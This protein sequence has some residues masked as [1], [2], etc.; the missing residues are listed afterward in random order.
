MPLLIGLENTSR[1]DPRIRIIRS[2]RLYFQGHTKR[3]LACL[4]SLQISERSV[5]SETLRK[6]IASAYAGSIQTAGRYQTDDQPLRMYQQSFSYRSVRSAW[7]RPSVDYTLRSINA[8]TISSVLNE[9]SVGNAVFVSALRSDIQ[10]GIGAAQTTQSKTEAIGSLAISSRW[11]NYFRSQ[12][13][14]SRQLYLNSISS[15]QQTVLRNSLQ[16]S[17]GYGKNESWLAEASGSI[18]NFVNGNLFSFHAWAMS[19]SLSIGRFSTRLGYSYSFSDASQST[20]VPSMSI[21]DFI[22]QA[23]N[24]FG[25]VP[26]FYNA[27]FSPLQQNIHQAIAKCSFRINS[28]WNII[29]QG[30]YGIDAYAQV[31]YFYLDQVN[32]QTAYVQSRYFRSFTPSEVSLSIRGFLGSGYYLTAGL[33]HLENNF[34]SRN[35]FGF[36]LSKM[37]SHE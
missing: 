17:L 4:D 6:E 26:A 35:G 3:A 31:P 14:A 36:T 13:K 20:Y 11:S 19:P 27:W 12:V 2:Q 37:L 21:S 34:Y 29:L 15:L 18:D 30:S 33:D 16:A 28:Q 8:D 22:K 23:S 25:H 32:G 1:M 24:D 5:T 7:F 10:F 9:L